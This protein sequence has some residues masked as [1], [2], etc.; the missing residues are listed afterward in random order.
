MADA[1]GAGNLAAWGDSYDIKQN[2][3]NV[4]SGRKLSG[5]GRSARPGPESRPLNMAASGLGVNTMFF[6][7]F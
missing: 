5:Y 7:F 3:H 1:K 2:T 4:E 6:P